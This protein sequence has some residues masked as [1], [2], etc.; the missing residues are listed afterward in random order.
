MHLS[1]NGG[2]SWEKISPDL[3]RNLPETIKSSGGPITQDNTGAEFYANIFA[4]AESE[5]EDNV[6][7]VGSDDGL[8]HITKDG[9]KNWENITPPARMSPKLNMINS[10]DP[11][12]FVK[13]KAY[14]AATSYKFGDYT[15]Y[16]YKTDDYGKSWTLITDGIN[17]DYYTRVVRSDKKRE[18]L[19]YAGTEWGMFISFND[20]K[21]WKEFQL[22]LPITSIRD[23]HV[24]DN[25]LV[26]ATHG[27]SFWVIDDLTPLHQINNEIQNNDAILFK[28]DTSYRLAQSGGWGNPDTLLSGE[29][30]PNGVIINYYLK[31][32]KKMII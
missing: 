22:N 2:Q 28:P 31:N 27:R 5:T 25:D 23:L 16:I 12:P 15:P 14:V 21:S 1:E 24:K 17:S 6:I 4:I 30:H 20:G 32:L 11:S 19:L 29:N 26:V 7:W 8:I 10:I 3:T 13:G 9:G 18:G